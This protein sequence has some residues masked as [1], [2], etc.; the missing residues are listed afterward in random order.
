MYTSK[1]QNHQNA[2]GHR[3]LRTAS[4]H[5]LQLS[6]REHYRNCQYLNYCSAMELPV[7]VWTHHSLQTTMYMARSTALWPN[8]FQTGLRILTI[9]KYF[10]TKVRCLKSTQK[11]EYSRKKADLH[12]KAQI[13]G[14]WLGS[15]L[16]VQMKRSFL[17]RNTA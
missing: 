9:S 15:I 3:Q 17:Q 1:S 13:D 14:S 4:V 8:T 10:F 16:P 12:N 6:Q 5:G 11:V 7:H 2:L